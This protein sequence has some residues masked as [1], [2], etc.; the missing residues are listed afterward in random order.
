MSLHLKFAYL[1]LEL[2]REILDYHPV[3]HYHYRINHGLINSMKSW[4][5]QGSRFIAHVENQS[6]AR[7][8]AES[9][10]SKLLRS[11]IV[12]SSIHENEDVSTYRHP[13]FKQWTHAYGSYG[14]DIAIKIGG[15]SPLYYFNNMNDN[16]VDVPAPAILRTNFWDDFDVLMIP[17]IMLEN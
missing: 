2:T 6:N 9:F 16:M 4:F 1:P 13:T 12:W 7:I 17:P 15:F 10:L 14:D 11:S 3:F 5:D 8:I